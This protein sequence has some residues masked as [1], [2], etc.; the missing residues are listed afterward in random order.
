[1]ARETVKALDKNEALENM[2]KIYRCMQM[3]SRGCSANC[4]TCEFYC[5]APQRGA[6]VEAVIAMWEPAPTAIDYIYTVVAEHERK[7]GYFQAKAEYDAKLNKLEEDGTDV[8]LN[9]VAENSYKR[10]LKAGYEQGQ[11]EREAILEE[12]KSQIKDIYYSQGYEQGKKDA[13]PKWIPVN[14]GLPN[15]PSDKFIDVY[16]TVGYDSTKKWTQELTYHDGA[17]YY[18]S[19]SMTICTL[20]VY[21][22]MPK[23]EP[24]P[25]KGEQHEQK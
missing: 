4:Y 13:A 21:A 14:E 20:D 23:V 25:W 17:W 7:R 15:I 12:I 11:T 24:E 8:R 2:K 19:P 9:I 10:G 5:S 3:E 1:M 22:W 6:T 16:C 18:P